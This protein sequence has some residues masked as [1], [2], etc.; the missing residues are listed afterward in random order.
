MNLLKSLIAIS[1]MTFIS[2]ILGFIRDTVIA[3]VFGAGMAT[4]A[5]FIAFK[6]PNLLRRIFAEGA[7]SQIFISVLVGYKNEQGDT[8]TRNFIAYIAGI[9]TLILTLITVFGMLT[10]PWIIF[11]TA[12]GFSDTPE[13]SALTTALLRITFPYILLI[14]LT[15][16]IG[17]ILNTWN[18]F[19][20]PAF[21]PTLLNISIICF[22][23]LATPLFNP[24]IMTLA[25]AVIVGGILQLSYQLPHLKKI[26]MMVM[27]KLRFHNSDVWRVLRLMGP[28]ML[29]VSVSQ[30]SLLI[31]NILLSYLVS[32][33]VSWIYYADRLM[34]FP[35]SIL[36]VAL[37]TILMPSLSRTFSNGDHDEYSRVL[38]W[39]LRL[40]FI[41]ALPSAIALGILSHPLT[42]VLFQYGKF[43]SFD[44]MM[45]QQA[46]MGYSIG[47][48]GMI[49]VKVLASGFYS[50]QDIKTPMYI[51]IVTLI[52]TQIMN[53][54]FIDLLK[55]AG[56]SLSIGLAA[57]LNAG[58]LYWQLCRQ[59]LFQPQPGWFRFLWKLIMAVFIM[60]ITLIYCLTIMP[61]WTQG[62]MLYRLTRLIGLVTLGVITYFSTLW[63]LTGCKLRDILNSTQIP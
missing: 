24:P 14:S 2:R 49:L 23:L 50:R 11:I 48:I 27:P 37:G 40:C 61:D 34:E 36:G 13:K 6:L 22:S 39:G 35:S 53:L 5:F 33:S 54:L 41:L 8:E 1:S 17:I 44:V 57:C 12:P 38:D 31:N 25:W 43:T 29:G 3:R 28:A 62:T 26:G 63:L 30:I 55:H 21:T 45:T 59:K 10:A 32:G 7:F 18:C 46:L 15:S 52:V 19:S 51:A 60:A 47:L 58:L 9:L 56:L 16:L 4:D 20:V 42:V